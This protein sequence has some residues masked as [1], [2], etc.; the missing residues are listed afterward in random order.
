MIGPTSRK[1][2]LTFGDNAVS[3]MDCRSLFHFPH[4]YKMGILRRFISISHTV[5]SR[6]FAILGDVTN[7]D[8]LMNPQHFASNPADIRIYPEIR[9]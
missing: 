2:W 6:F 4:H 7:A 3:D 8:K 9:I 1:N 5:A